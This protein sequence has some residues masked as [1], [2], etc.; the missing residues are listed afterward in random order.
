L[1]EWEEK[2]VRKGE[3]CLRCPHV[4]HQHESELVGLEK[5]KWFLNEGSCRGLGTYIEEAW[6]RVGKESNVTNPC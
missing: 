6:W 4:F 5:G 2:G 3:F 1:R